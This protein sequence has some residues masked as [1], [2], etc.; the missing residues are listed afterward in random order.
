MFEGPFGPRRICYS[1]YT[2]SGRP[3]SFIEEYM[4]LEVAPMY[5]NTHTEASGT[6]LQTSRFRED[7]RSIVKECVN[8]SEEDVVI[9]VGSGATAAIKKLVDVLGIHI[10]KDLDKRYDLSSQIPEEERPVVFIGPYEHHSNELMWRESIADVFEIKED[11][12][13]QISLQHLT[14]MLKKYKHRKFKIGSFSAASNVTGI[15]T[16]TEAITELLH[17]HGALSFWDFAAAA[18]YVKI[19]M[20]PTGEKKKK[21]KKDE[22]E[23]E[24]PLSS[25]QIKRRQLL[26]KDAVF[27][28]PH[29]FPGGPGTPGV[30]VAKKHLFQNTI[31]TVPGGGTVRWVT[32][33]REEYDPNV[34]HREEG[35]TPAIMESIRCGLVFQLKH[36][37]GED[38]IAQCESH[39][40]SKAIQSWEANPN[41]R[42]LGNTAVPRVAI[43]SLLIYRGKAALHHNFVVSLLND[44]FGVQARGGCSCAGPYGMRLLALG[45][46]I[47]EVIYQRVTAGEVVIRPGWVR[48]NFNYFYS[49]TMTDYIISAVNFIAN[50]GWKFLPYYRLVESSGE[51]VHRMYVR[52]GKAERPYIS[53]KS[54]NYNGGK[55]TYP[56]PSSH[57]T[58]GE[59]SLAHNLVK[60]KVLAN[61]AVRLLSGFRMKESYNGGK[62]WFL[63]PDEALAALQDVEGD[64]CEEEKV[65]A[66][67]S[68]LTLKP[69]SYPM[70]KDRLY[71]DDDGGVSRMSEH[72]R[73]MKE[74]A[75]IKPLSLNKQDSA[76]LEAMMKDNNGMKE[77]EPRKEKKKKKGFFFCCSAN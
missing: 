59:D 38:V 45:D 71:V 18:P 20:N 51:W 68:D 21:N 55:M 11:K 46:E 54:I 53:L 4:R 16:D 31:P 35:G 24:K 57:M 74:D 64:V 32:S 25:K 77:M 60:A 8:G 36:S 67:D 70:K 28:S 3:L 19:D 12:N 48:V 6:G 58:L 10:P 1:D 26:A 9:F 2:A 62:R 29:K 73:K 15:S 14:S 37:I 66:S 30:L 41:I 50:H 42:V 43:V 44:L 40:L 13:G 49:D 76:E 23:E 75:L 72:V 27:I 17:K 52:K 7:A 56:R 63:T 47:S 69:T 22:E 65:R 5:A 34:I 33:K 39:H 61:Q